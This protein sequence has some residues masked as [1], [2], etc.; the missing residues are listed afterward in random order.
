MEGNATIIN[1]KALNN[2]EQYFKM[3]GIHVLKNFLSKMDWLAKIDLEN[4]F[5]SILHSQKTQ[6]MSQ[7]HFQ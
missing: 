2:Y 3:E 7:V 1:L 6:K 5:L 4:A